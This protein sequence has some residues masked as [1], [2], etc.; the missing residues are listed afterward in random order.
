MEAAQLAGKPGVGVTTGPSSADE[1][2]EAGATAV[3]ASLEHF[4]AWLDQQS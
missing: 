1:L 3:L 4:P 2:R